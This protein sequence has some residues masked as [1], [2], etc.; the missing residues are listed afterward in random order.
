MAARDITGGTRTA[1]DGEGP[2]A[3]EWAALGKGMGAWQEEGLGGCG[4]AEKG[5]ALLLYRRRKG[6]LGGLE[7]EPLP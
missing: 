7:T 3:W 4:G 5:A 1:F 6:V 2:G